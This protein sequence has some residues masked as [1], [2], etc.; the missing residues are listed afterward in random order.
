MDAWW[1]ESE[2]PH[3]VRFRWRTS[4]HQG[5]GVNKREKLPLPGCESRSWGIGGPVHRCPRQQRSSDDHMLSGR[6][7]RG[8]A[9]PACRTAERWHPRGA[10]DQ[11]GADPAGGRCRASDAVIAST[12]LVGVS[13]VYRTKRRFVEGNLE[14]ALSEEARPGASRKLSG[15]ETALLVATACSTPP[16]GR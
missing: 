14:A 8:G 6:S 15:K 13:T 16:E 4:V 11:A 12:V 1:R 3:H 2:E 7:E 10:Q 5:V 9:Y